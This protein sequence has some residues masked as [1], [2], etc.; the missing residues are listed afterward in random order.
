MDKKLSSVLVTGGAGYVGSALV[1]MLLD[2]GHEVTV[3]DL[4]I[5]GEKIFSHLSSHP[6][7]HQIK[8]DIR[9]QE[10]IREAV[11][12]CDTII[13]L[14][15]IS[16]DPSYDLNPNLGRSINYDSFKPLIKEAK[17]AGCDVSYMRHPRLFM[18]L[19]VRMR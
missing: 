3:H 12:N 17:R 6:K 10:S 2:A 18:A 15:C 9:D 8:G 13:H 11:K 16:N 19:R 4:F 14:A 7:L 1:P 5:Y